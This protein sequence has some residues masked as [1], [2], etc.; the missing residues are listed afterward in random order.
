MKR[1]ANKR[2]LFLTHPWRV[3]A[4]ETESAVFL[5]VRRLLGARWFEGGAFSE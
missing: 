2:N 1:S 5:G 4:P 3:N